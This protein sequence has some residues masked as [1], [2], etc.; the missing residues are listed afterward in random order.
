LFC[1][2]GAWGIGV[3]ASE[4]IAVVAAAGLSVSCAKQAVASIPT[5][6]R[7]RALRKANFTDK[8]TAIPSSPE[9]CM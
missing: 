6:L 3:S 5:R 7:V 8:E 9:K 2:F 1:G 4:T